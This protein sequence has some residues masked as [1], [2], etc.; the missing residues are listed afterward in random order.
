[1]DGAI[2]VFVSMGIDR[3][4]HQIRIETG[5]KLQGSTAEHTSLVPTIPA[6]VPTDAVY[7]DDIPGASWGSWQSHPITPDNGA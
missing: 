2:Y 1:V 3:D 5:G 6:D 4:R 7:V